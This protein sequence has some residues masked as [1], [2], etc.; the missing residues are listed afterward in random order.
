MSIPV[1]IENKAR[2]GLINGPVWTDCCQHPPESYVASFEIANYQR[3]QMEHYDLYVYA[4]KCSG[5]QDVCIR[6]GDECSQYISPGPLGGFLTHNDHEPY[7]TAI[8]IL[9]AFGKVSWAANSV[10]E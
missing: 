4:S 9:L 3:Q 6:Y 5:K 8:R 10:T 2:Y 1:T 7:M